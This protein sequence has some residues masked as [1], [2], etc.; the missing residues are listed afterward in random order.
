MLNSLLYESGASMI[1][2]HLQGI[3]NYFENPT[4][5]GLIEGMNT[6]IKLIKRMSYGFTNFQHLRLK[7]FAC[8]NS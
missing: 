1:Q 5:N 2:K 6:K 8:F 7:L 3:C 4:T